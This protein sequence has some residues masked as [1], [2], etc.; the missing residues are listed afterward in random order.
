MTIWVDDDVVATGT[1]TGSMHRRFGV[2][3]SS[4]KGN[5]TRDVH[6]PAGVHTVRVRVADNS[7]FDQTRSITINLANDSKTSLQV[8]ANARSLALSSNAKAELAPRS[9]TETASVSKYGTPLLLSVGSTAVSATIAFFITE[10]L[11][12]VRPGTQA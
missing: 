2:G 7:G 3:S 11:K 1:L 6:V 12:K 8:A 4:M 5:W 10:L 9:G